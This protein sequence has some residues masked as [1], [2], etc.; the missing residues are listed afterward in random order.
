MTSSKPDMSAKPSEVLI[1]D[2]DPSVRGALGRL[3]RASGFETHVFTCPSALLAAD[4]PTTNACLVLDFYLPEMSGIELY[5]ALDAAGR[6]LPTVMITGKS[7]VD[8]SLF[9]PIHPVAVLIKPFDEG[10]LLEAI[11]KALDSGKRLNEH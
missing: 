2:D 6:A 3:L 5:A 1:V 7:D 4:I 8:R 10:V 11:S 9:D